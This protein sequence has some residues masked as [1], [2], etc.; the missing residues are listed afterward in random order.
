MGKVEPFGEDDPN[1][2]GFAFVVTAGI[3][4]SCFAI[5]YSCRFDL[6]TDFAGSTNFVVLAIATLLLSDTYY[7]RQIAVTAMLCISRLELALFLL[8]RV[9]TRK[10]DARFDDTRDSFVKFLIFWIFQIFWVYLVSF[11]VIWVNA[12][13]DVNPTFG[14]LDYLG[15][16]MWAVG[17]IVQLTADFQKLLFRKNPANKLKICKRGFWAYSRHP[18][19][20]GEILMWWGIFLATLPVWLE[21]GHEDGWA[22]IIS[23][24]FTMLIL[25]FLSGMPTAEGSALE[26]WYTH[27]NDLKAE[28]TEYRS[29]TAPIIICCPPVYAALPMWFKRAF[30]CEFRRYEFQASEMG[31][32][33]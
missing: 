14:P 10:K 4:L 8:Y 2:L 13:D 30:C 15:C 26:R 23:P 32:T 3:Q 17:F 1:Y 27:G 19:Y 9:C 24:L 20:Y 29:R 6:I 21:S 25:L 22:T 12:V 33:S 28:Y 18:N 31:L 5:A 7:S 11:P 16:I